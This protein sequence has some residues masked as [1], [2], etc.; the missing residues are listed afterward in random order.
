MNRR[1]AAHRA[2]RDGRRHPS[3]DR[4]PVNAMTERLNARSSASA[5]KMARTLAG[6]PVDIKAP[7]GE[8]ELLLGDV[9]NC[10]RFTTSE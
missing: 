2:R 3:T 10:R 7:A 8:L 1:R 4:V 9:D 5:R 6:V